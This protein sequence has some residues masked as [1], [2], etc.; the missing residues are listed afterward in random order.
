MMKKV[1]ILSATYKDG[2]PE[3]I[4]VYGSI[5]SMARGFA[6]HI[7]YEATREA[8]FSAAKAEDRAKDEQAF[9]VE[10]AHKIADLLTALFDLDPDVEECRDGYTVYGWEEQEVQW[11]GI[12]ADGEE[13]NEEDEE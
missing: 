3:N 10:V 12:E 5:R 11:T 13:E 6:E 9:N 8:T 1:Y 2:D 7:L 4:G